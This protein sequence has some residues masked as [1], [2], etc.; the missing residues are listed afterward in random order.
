MKTW[1]RSKIYACDRG[2][3]HSADVDRAGWESMTNHEPTVNRPRVGL[4]DAEAALLKRVPAHNLLLI[5]PPSA[6]RACIDDLT[7]SLVPPVVCWDG[8][9]ADLP[10]D[11][12]GSLVI[13]DVSSL[14]PALQHRLLEWLNNQSPRRT[15]IATSIEPFYRNVET[16]R[17]NTVTVQ[18]D[19]Q[20]D[21]NYVWDAA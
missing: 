10:A 6:T 5:G 11:S 3:T 19:R 14:T 16:D 1:I 21:T 20:P 7:S 8:G 9:T 4:Q 13:P 17:L 18:L 15:V 2:T 12:I